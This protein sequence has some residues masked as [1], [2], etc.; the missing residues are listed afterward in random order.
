MNNLVLDVGGSAIKYALMTDQ[1]VFI[2]KGQVPTPLDT[3]EHFTETIGRLYDRYQDRIEGIAISMPGL[4]DSI[5]GYAISGGG[6][7]KYNDNQPIVT[8]LQKRCPVPI[9]IENDGKCAAL[10]E[11]WM[12]SLSDCED[13]IVVVLGTG[14]AGGIIKNKRLHRGR[15]FAAGE[16]SYL[17]NPSSFHPESPILWHQAGSRGLSKSVSDAKGIPI[18]ALDG[19]AVFEM[20]NNEDETVLDILNAYSRNIAILLFNLQ[21]VYDPERIAIGGGISAQDLLMDLI[22]KNVQAYATTY[23]HIVTPTVV[24]CTYRNDSNLIGAL[25]HYLL[26]QNDSQFSDTPGK[27]NLAR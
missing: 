4:I 7:L 6:V 17:Y 15:H 9:T 3:N 16:F 2:E 12:G 23:E 8:I 14:V 21:H 19:R 24:S 27:T 20:A 5:R 10:A 26:T 22:Q 11:A 18:E 25:Y 13:G 1:A